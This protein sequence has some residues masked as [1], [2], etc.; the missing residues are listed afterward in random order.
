MT[1]LATLD[2]VSEAAQLHVLQILAR[3]AFQNVQGVVH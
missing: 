1:I 3:L 2:T